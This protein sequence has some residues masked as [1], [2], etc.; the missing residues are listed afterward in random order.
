MKIG[1][2][3]ILT[4]T[5]RIVGRLLHLSTIQCEALPKAWYALAG[6]CYKWGRKA[7]DNASHGSVQL[8][9]DERAQI[10]SLLPLVSWLQLY[11]QELTEI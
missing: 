5:D 10:L 7:V 11:F 4:D 6:W 1:D 8:F 2:N 9:P 3:P